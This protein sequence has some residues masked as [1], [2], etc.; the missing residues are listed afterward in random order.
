MDLLNKYIN[1][2]QM[3]YNLIGMDT[4]KRIA[5][6][7]K[8]MVQITNYCTNSFGSSCFYAFID[9]INAKDLFGAYCIGNP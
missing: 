9:D 6:E 7:G 4:V 1:I 3:L 8:R 2:K 5:S